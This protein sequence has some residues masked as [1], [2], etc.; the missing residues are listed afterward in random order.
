M[1]EWTAE[2]RELRERFREWHGALSEGHLADDRSSTFSRPRWDLVRESG[3]LRLP[4]DAAHGGSGHDL[5]TTMYV[6][7]DL[8][9]GCR[10]G[11][12]LFSISTHI[13]STGI[14]IQRF[15]SEDLRSRYLDA[16]C[17]G[18]AIGAHAI[19]EPDAG[20]NAMHME[21]SATEDG[22]FFVLDG[23]KSYISNGPVAD[24][25]VVYARTDPESTFQ[26]IT[27]FVVERGDPGFTVGEPVEKMG[28]RTSPFCDLTF[29]GCRVPKSNIVGR[30]GAGFLILEYVLAWEILSLFIMTVGAMQHRFERCV[31]FAN[32]RHQFGAPI[33]V[34][35]S[36]ADKLVDMKIGVES[37]RKWLY[38]TGERHARKENVTTALAIAK[39]VTSEAN[40]AS[41]TAAVQLFGG[42]GYLS[43]YG[44]EKDLR[45]AIGGTIYSGTSEMQRRRISTMIGL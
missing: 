42:R 43:E 24:L 39:L 29:E 28:M 15:G 17:D 20:S 30:V 7:E 14:P 8:G 2:Q 31:D 22:D 44:L 4:F 12:L 3:L 6:L 9:Y 34:N 18:A 41:A 40:V 26:G 11:G 1:I 5:L 13:V 45:D 10:D 27:A 35:Q 19:S 23:K 25:F 38:D 36:I 21:T 33:G 16:V 37:S 32:N